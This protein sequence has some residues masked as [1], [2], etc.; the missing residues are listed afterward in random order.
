M[1]FYSSMP[2][3]SWISHKRIF[4]KSRRKRYVECNG[5]N[6]I[7]YSSHA[8]KLR[9]NK[10]G[11]CMGAICA[12]FGYHL[13]FQRRIKTQLGYF[14]INGRLNRLVR[15][16]CDD[17]IDSYASIPLGKVGF[18]LFFKEN[19]ANIFW[20]A[21]PPGRIQL[22]WSKNKVISCFHASNWRAVMR[23][24]SHSLQQCDSG[25]SYNRQALHLVSW[26]VHGNS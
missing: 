2:Y 17:Q 23:H 19:N 8:I 6:Y 20:D 25:I 12:T 26:R 4:N 10:N 5:S 24:H 14:K 22:G 13:G 21:S 1:Y 7:C 15:V 3:I 16:R 11:K 18:Q 9:W